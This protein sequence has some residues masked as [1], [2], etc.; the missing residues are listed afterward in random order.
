MVNRFIRP[1]LPP[2]N[3]IM[4]HKKRFEG[5]VVVDVGC[6]TSILSIFCAWAG[7]KVPPHP[8]RGILR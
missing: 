3:A 6:G 7:A 2:P 4:H 1:R 5:K 8:L